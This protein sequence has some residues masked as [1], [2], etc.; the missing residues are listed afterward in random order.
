MTLRSELLIL[1]VLRSPTGVSLGAE[2]LFPVKRLPRSGVEEYVHK[3]AKSLL[4]F[5]GLC[6]FWC[7]CGGWLRLLQ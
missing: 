7:A 2:G 1:N 3:E 6:S 5:F 4:V